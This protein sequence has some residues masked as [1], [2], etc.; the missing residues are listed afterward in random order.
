MAHDPILVK[1]LATVPYYAKDRALVQN[2]SNPRVWTSP[3]WNSNVPLADWTNA[4]R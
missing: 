3:D 1:S 4:V 2:L